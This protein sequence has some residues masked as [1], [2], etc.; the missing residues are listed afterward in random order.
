MNLAISVKDICIQFRYIRTCMMSLFSS[1]SYVAIF[2]AKLGAKYSWAAVIVA[3]SDLI[4][5]LVLY[6]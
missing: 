3:N 5:T 4:V 1:C 2:I 6:L